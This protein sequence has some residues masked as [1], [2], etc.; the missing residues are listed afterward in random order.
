MPILSIFTP[1]HLCSM[2]SLPSELPVLA[3]PYAPYSYKS[4]N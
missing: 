4:K 2:F 1:K 3:T